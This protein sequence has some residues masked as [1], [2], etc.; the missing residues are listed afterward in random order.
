MCLCYVITLRAIVR[1][2]HNLIYRK[3][4]MRLLHS[5]LLEELYDYAMLWL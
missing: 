2:L 1:W 4:Q 5:F 3:M